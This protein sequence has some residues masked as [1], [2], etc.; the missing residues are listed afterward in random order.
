M[1]MLAGAEVSTM[2]TVFVLLVAA[3][4]ALSQFFRK[5]LE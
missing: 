5:G 1:K 4:D 3:A 2:L